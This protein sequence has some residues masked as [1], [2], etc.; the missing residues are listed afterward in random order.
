MDGLNS[1]G[2]VSTLLEGI[3]QAFDRAI[4]FEKIIGGNKTI[5]VNGEKIKAYESKLVIDS[6]NKKR[7]RDTFINSLTS[8]IDFIAS[9]QRI[10]DAD[11]LD[12]PMDR[13]N[14]EKLIDDMGDI[15]V[16]LYTRG[17]D[18]YLVKMDLTWDDGSFSLIKNNNE[19]YELQF[20]NR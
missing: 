20:E 19:N 4:S 1:F 10:R 2:Y 5:E 7:F 6:N 13:D 11:F 9:L 8:N 15:E 14:L 3:N 17:D 16:S 12:L 18:H